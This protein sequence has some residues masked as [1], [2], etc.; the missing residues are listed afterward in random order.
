MSVNPS[1]SISYVLSKSVKNYMDN[2]VVMLGKYTRTRDAARILRHYERDDIIVT[3]ENKKAIGIVTDRD[4]LG[5]VSDSTVYAETTILKDIM[6]S[7]L[8][9]IED[10]A[11]LQEALHK[12]RC[13]ISSSNSMVRLCY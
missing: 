4:I 13:H 7:P 5:K 2:D 8:I 9:T 6:S 11:T 12:M 1:K 10:N 3:D